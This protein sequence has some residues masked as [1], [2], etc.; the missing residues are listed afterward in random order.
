MKARSRILVPGLCSSILTIILATTARAGV[1]RVI[2]DGTGDSITIQGGIDLAQAGDTVSVYPGVYHEHVE[3]AKDLFVEARRDADVTVIDG[4]FTPGVVVHIH[5]PGTAESS[6]GG[7]T[8]RHGRISETTIAAAGIQVSIASPRVHDNV[9][10]NNDGCGVSTAGGSHALIERN[11]CLRNAVFG[12]LDLDA[13]PVIRDNRFLSSRIGIYFFGAAPSEISGNVIS[14][15][16][17]DGI[18]GVLNTGTALLRNNTVVRNGMGMTLESDFDTLLVQKNVVARN[19]SGGI[20]V[21][22]FGRVLPVLDTN[23]VWNNGGANY[24]AID[25]GPTDISLD[26]LF[27]DPAGGD[28]DIGSAS[29]CNL[30]PGDFIGAFGIGC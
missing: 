8:V 14:G 26:P 9:V 2:P 4:D 23:D 5:G 29:P 3:I 16:V 19:A 15:N 11:L 27:C 18:Y 28:Y 13:T 6:F 7:F 30:G 24:I 12:F 1:V 25:P 21:E 17:D 10:R 20:F 22:G